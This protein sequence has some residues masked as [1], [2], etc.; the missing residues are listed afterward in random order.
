MSN[1]FIIGQLAKTTTN[2]NLN[3]YYNCKVGCLGHDYFG[4]R[5]RKQGD[6]VY[7]HSQLILNNLIVLVIGIGYNSSAEWN[8]PAYMKDPIEILVGEE[9]IFVTAG[10]IEELETE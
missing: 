10:F 8:S 1:K 7:Y 5:V 2:R 9:K 4:A 3:C 6:K